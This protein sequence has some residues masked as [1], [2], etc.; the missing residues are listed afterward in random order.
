MILYESPTAW[1]PAAQAVATEALGPLAPNWIEI[2]P[3][4]MLPI[5][6]GMKKGL[7]RLGPLPLYFN[8]GVFQYRK[9]PQPTAG[10]HTDSVGI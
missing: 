4:A 3:G 1:A 8:A 6:M 10:E 5:I 7:T 9:A 2:M